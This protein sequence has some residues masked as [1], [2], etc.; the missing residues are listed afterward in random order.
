MSLLSPSK[1]KNLYS[2]LTEEQKNEVKR[3]GLGVTSQVLR[4]GIELSRMLTDPSE[5]QI[6][7]TEDFLEKLYTQVAGSENV[8]RV[9]R[10][11]REVVTIAEPKSGAAQVV[12]DI[13]SFAGTM[14][15]LGKIAKPLQA[16]KPVQK[17]TQVAPKTIATTG[18]I[19]RGETAAQ[20]SLNPF[21]ENF[22]NVVG[23]MID[24][25]SEGL[26]ADFEKYMLEPIKSSQEK[27]ELQNR[28]G[29]LAE[30]LIFTGAF[31]AVS[32]GI[33]NREAISKSFFNTL[34]SIKGQGKEV[35]EAFM[36]NLKRV[37]AQDREF[38]EEAVKKRQQAVITDNQPELF[39]ME[40]V[41]LG[42]ID[43]LKLTKF[44]TIGTLRSI[45][46]A[47]A[48]TFTPRGGRSELLHENYLKTQNAKEKWNATIDHTAR[49]LE[50]S[51]NNIYKE[52]GGNKQ[53]ILDDLN[54]VLF[55][56]FKV[57]PTETQQQAFE[58]ALLK[59]PE[60]TRESIR[61]ARNLQDQL[62]K[63]L[64]KS[65]NVAPADK[66]IIEDQ[67]GFY[68]RES[69]KMFEDGGYI[70]TIQATNT[71]RRFIAQRIKESNPDITPRR[72]RLET[73]AEMDKLAG[74]KGDFVNFS[75]GFETFGKVREG[76]LVEKQ[77]VPPAI[78][79]YLGEIT[80]PIDKL[81]IS[82]KKIAQFVEDSNFHNQAYKDGKDIYFHESDNLPGFTAQIPKYDDVKVQPFGELSGMYTTPELA[83]Y[84]TKRY[85]QGLSKVIPEGGIFGSGWRYLLFLKSQAQKSATTRRISTHIKNIFG[86]AQITGANGFKLLNPKT[87]AESFK[88]V[89]N[90]LT[91]T[92]NI[93]QQQFIEELAGQGVLNKNAIINDLRN[94]SKDASNVKF[95]GAKPLQYLESLA[96]RAPGVKQLLKGDEKVTELYIAEDDFWKINMYLNEK[97]HL[98][99]FTKALPNNN[100]FDKFRYDTPQKLQNEAGKITREG[101]PNYD[102][103]PDNLKE[104]RS[105]PFIGTF[106]SFLSES[107]RLAMTIP[108]QG[109]KEIKL[110]RELKNMG[111]NEASDIMRNRAI[112]RFVGYSTFGLGGGA[113]ATAVANYS[114][115]VG[116]DV[117]DNIKPFLPEW[118]QNDNVVYTLNEEGVPIVYNITPWDAFDFPRKPFQ[119]ILHKTLNNEDLTE[120]EL[121]Q[122]NYD[123]VN[124][125]F[126]PFFGQSLT[127]EIFNAAIFNNGR[128]SNGSLLKNPLNKLE[129]YNPEAESGA[130]D[131]QNM[132]IIAMNL[133][134][135]LEPGTVTDTRKYFRDK[136]GKEM[137][138]LGQKIYRDEAMFKWLTGFGG[139]PFNKEYVESIYSFKVSDFNSAKSKGITQIYRAITDDMTKEEFINNFL[140]A[141]REYYKS[142]KELHTLTEAAENLKLN[143]LD[144]L[145]ESGVSENDRYSFLGG[146]RYFK[147]LSITE[148]M[149]KR[150]L[151]S[152]SLQKEYIDILLEVDKLSRALNQLPVLIDPEN[153]KEMSM[154]V[155]DEVDK[156]FK[157][158]RLPKVTG[159]LVLGPEVPDTKE[160]P[161]DRVN[162][163]T[164]SPY[165]D[166]MA[167]LG[168]Q[169]GGAVLPTL[170]FADNNKRQLTQEE[171]NR[172]IAIDDY[173]KGKGYRKEARAGILGNIHIETGGS[174]S[175]TQIEQAKNKQLGYGIFQL[176]GKKKDFDKWM[177]E[178]KFD[179]ET[180][181][182]LPMQ[183]EY[184]HET[185]YGNELI[186]TKKGREIGAGTANKLQESFAKGTA[187]EIA[188]TFSNEWEK[189]G[190]PHNEQRIKAASTLF[191]ILPE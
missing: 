183:I 117:I 151:E 53:N 170:I 158:L 33:R 81:L 172:M 149:Q 95:F 164:G 73:Q 126:T 70:P 124:E 146:N 80:S 74:G 97:K 185:I 90:Q 77:N 38:F 83:E 188:L 168:L 12:R 111:A 129:V 138:P 31:G 160:D 161:A 181:D 3:T 20:L 173:L 128:D 13:G 43:A 52:I 54:E 112:D 184:M 8:E 62:S 28:L 15:G 18:F 4:E 79:S 75:S 189:P 116:Q 46:N 135:V 186:G 104:I 93:E 11:D 34:D 148:P 91:R 119:T 121:Q 69:Y 92:S 76:I 179:K 84:Y 140:N 41:D 177:T 45:S 82:M 100:T 22:A 71:A 157:D 48:K 99:T 17:A 72:L 106:F 176:T 1:L 105:V 141:N 133:V 136:F 40:K 156:I 130:F 174:F 163:F 68:V 64:L 5:S 127:Q 88:T 110:A 155:S 118:M 30:G 154:P 152:P 61:K 167:R 6:Q 7:S 26:L 123:L 49:N 137:T 65:E 66:K 145:K 131:K 166:Q 165:S 191:N 182:E 67:L 50:N 57:K 37:R 59:F 56:K 190:I 44:S 86:G 27:S 144:L 9:Q 58:K 85:Q 102:L 175:P 14:A 96:K 2:L 42:D 120:E 94:M 180:V 39:S 115:G 101:L 98:D 178:N 23:D 108:R 24:E 89:Y 25:D 21:Q 147:P 103:V 107:T 35:S 139:I 114:A 143:T 169:D 78:K 171:F 10:G 87:T 187:E 16:L 29:L 36:N 125:I 134:E 51:I 32:S 47:L 19:A 150:I 153:T 142:Y 63:L 113:A 159:G 122:Y 55:T 162:P 109:I 60:P 132:K